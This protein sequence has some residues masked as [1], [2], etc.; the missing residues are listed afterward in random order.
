MLVASLVIAVMTSIGADTNFY[1]AESW[2][3]PTTV[4]LETC[5]QMAG[6]LNAGFDYLIRQGKNDGWQSKTASCEIIMVADA[7]PASFTPP[8]KP[9]LTF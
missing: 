2:Q 5:A 1:Q 3:G 4:E 7:A 8:A 9:N 6:D